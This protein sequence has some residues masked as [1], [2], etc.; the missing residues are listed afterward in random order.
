MALMSKGTGRVPPA[1][2]AARICLAIALLIVTG[3][4]TLP[5]FY[6][7]GPTLASWWL[8]SYLDLDKAQKASTRSALRDWFRWHRDTQLV[9]YADALAAL[10]ADAM[11]DLS[12]DRVCGVNAEIRQVFRDG[13]TQALP[14]FARLGSALSAQQRQLLARRYAESNEELRDEALEGTVVERRARTAAEAIDAAKDLYGRLDRDQKAFITRRIEASPYNAE[15]WLAERE[16]RQRD[17]LATL[18]QIAALPAGAREGGALPMLAALAATFTR[19]P[20]PAYREYH[21]ALTRYNCAL[22]ADVHNRMNAKQRARAAHK[23]AGWEADLRGLMQQPG[24]PDRAD[25][26]ATP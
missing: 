12:S 3:C 26:A 8:D 7:R 9:R 21:T 25:Q 5:L 13:L 18:E 6:T 17:T 14:A 23:L 1:T 20:R 11:A 4:S 15:H 24:P 10:R 19:S 2:G 16:A 22:I